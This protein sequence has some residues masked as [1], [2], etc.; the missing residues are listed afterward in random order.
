MNTRLVEPSVRVG[1]VNIR[2]LL[3]DP[4]SLVVETNGFFAL[5]A[6]C[7][8]TNMLFGPLLQAFDTSEPA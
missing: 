6:E 1:L 3:H 4:N 7:V 2:L 5:R 8:V